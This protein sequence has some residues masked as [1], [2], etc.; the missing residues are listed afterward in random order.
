MSSASFNASEGEAR[1]FGQGNLG[2]I[3]D[4]DQRAF[5]QVRLVIFCLDKH[6][7]K[8]IG[9]GKPPSTWSL[10]FCI[11]ETA[12]NGIGIITRFTKPSLA[13]SDR[14]TISQIVQGSRHG[15]HIGRYENIVWSR[16]A[17]RPMSL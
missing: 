13:S 17:T 8:I 11:D 15:R 16:S 2:E 7:S 5:R 6:A 12:L 4:I 9:V 10:S 3:K 14:E 1:T